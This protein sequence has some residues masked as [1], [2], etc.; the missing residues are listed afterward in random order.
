M[1]E[2][3][4]K[5]EKRAR[6][7]L[8]LGGCLFALAVAEVTLRLAFPLPSGNFIHRPNL[9]RTFRPSPGVMPGVEGESEFR[10]NSLGIRGSEIPKGKTHRILAIGGS[11]TECLYLDQTEAWPALLEER[12]NASVSTPEVWIGNAG[13]T[14]VSTREHRLQIPILLDDIKRI[15]RVILLAGVNDLLLR[16]A[17]DDRYDPD[18]VVKPGSREFLM[19]RAFDMVRPAT[20][21]HRVPFFPRRFIGLSLQLFGSLLGYQEKETPMHLVEDEAGRLYI[22]RR[23]FRKNRMGTRDTLPDLSTGLREFGKNLTDCI[24]AAKDRKVDIVLV[25]QPV[26][27]S[28]TLTPDQEDLLWTGGVGSISGENLEYYSTSA[29]AAGMQKYNDRMKE[30]ATKES[31]PFYDLA[32]HLPKDTTVFY[33]DCHFNEQGAERVA[34]QLTEFLLAELP[35]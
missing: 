15:D 33:D 30:L 16:L 25:S 19:S 5:K 35:N 23:R 11:T 4:E 22:E 17:V 24:Q 12:L 6:A 10:V 13:K 26:L 20:D 7:L 18:F 2:R 14:G 1:N 32:E 27:W 29:L 28:D 21:V 8:V 3:T 9:V 34:D 31:I